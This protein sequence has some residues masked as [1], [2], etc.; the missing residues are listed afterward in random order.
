MRLTA[1]TYYENSMDFCENCTA[2]RYTGST[3]MVDCAPCSIGQYSEKDGA[4]SC[5]YCESPLSSYGESSEC[6][7]S[8][9]ACSHVTFDL[10]ALRCT[11]GLHHGSLL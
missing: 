7:V 2:G 5:A 9:H 3:G 10:I 4:S 1:G 8:S 6:T 11:K